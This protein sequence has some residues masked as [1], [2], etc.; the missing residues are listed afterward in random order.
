MIAS[1]AE[2]DLNTVAL[3]FDGRRLGQARRLRGKLKVDLAED[4]EV[5]P[6]AIGQFERG[7]S[8]PRPGTIAKMSLALH[9]PPAFFAERVFHEIHEDEA[10]FRR[11]RATSKRARD[12]ARAQVELLADLVEC[13]ERRVR[14]PEVALPRDL[15]TVPETAAKELRERWSLGAGPVA[16]MVGLLERRGVVVARL[17]SSSDDVDAFSCWLGGRPFVLLSS[18]KDAPDRSRF[19]A[20]HELGH[21][22]IHH[23]VRPGD[24][25]TENEAHRFAAEFLMPADSIIGELPAR[26][27]WRRYFELKARWGTSIASLVRR[28]HDLEVISEASY[29]RAMIEMGRKGWRT[30]EPSSGAAPEDP[31]LLLRA[32]GL[33]QEH[34]QVT[35]QDI[36]DE[37]ALPVAEVLSLAAIHD[38]A[39]PQSLLQL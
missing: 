32:L 27:N 28:A 5:T 19:D 35:S 20:A 16:T 15:G 2:T 4:V 34:R 23:D 39:D 38:A 8:R 21:L 12:E 11:L 36:A 24:Q 3:K 30:Q 18:N 17:R 29:R 6:A 13:V 26:L 25:T 9:M 22:A 10:H 33:L 7:D 31:E 37:L 14:L 1:V